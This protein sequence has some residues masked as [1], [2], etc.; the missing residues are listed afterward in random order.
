[1]QKN[2][3]F[4]ITLVLLLL[5]CNPSSPQKTQITYN[6][7]DAGLMGVVSP[8]E[9]EVANI[10]PWQPKILMRVAA[11]PVVDLRYGESGELRFP[12]PGRQKMS[13]C[14]GWAS[15]YSLKTYLEAVEHNWKLD[16][17]SRIFSPSFVYNQINGGKNRG[18]TIYNALLLFQRVGAA[19]LETMP[20]TLN[21]RKRPSRSA[22]REANNY[23]IK[24]F[25]RL[26]S[27]ADIRLALQ[28]GNP[29]LVHV[30]TDAT[31]NSGLYDVYTRAM[32]KKA[33]RVP[34]HIHGRHAM[35]IAGY[36][37]IGRTLLFINSWGKYWGTKGFARV[38]YDVI[39]RIRL[40]SAGT[41]FL[42]EAYIAIDA[43]SHKEKKKTIS[44]YGNVYYTGLAQ[45]EP[46]WSW[47]VY[48][49]AS[50]KTFNA[51]RSIRWKF[52]RELSPLSISKSSA[53]NFEVNGVGDRIG[54][55]KAIAYIKFKDGTSSKK[56]YL[57]DFHKTNRRALQLVQTDRYYGRVQKRPYWNWSL[58]IKGTLNDLHDIKKVTY[59]LHPTFPKPN[60]VVTRSAENGFQFSSRGWGTFPVKAT[61]LFQDGTSK[62]LATSLKFRSKV[63]DRLILTNK[64]IEAF[65]DTNGRLIYNWT[66]YLKGPEKILSSIKQVRYYLHRTFRKNKIDVYQQKYGFPLSRSGWGT[67]EIK[68]KVFFRNGRTKVLKHTLKF[69]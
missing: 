19:T 12:N 35:V 25:K 40:D 55:Y 44:L 32:R 37:D 15:A 6:Q 53:N 41:Y 63:E 30:I 8:E 23:K 39:D 64:A 11:A 54:Q 42:Q 31:F 22:Y 18:A 65:Q 43:H 27:L 9:Q 60:R 3:L 7:G 48:L 33:K 58:R 67:F 69:R 2:T 45:Q 46:T 68:A 4:L 61:V 24:D 62:R 13:D 56:T 26:R 50:E 20:Y 52:S 14:V 49:E 10:K 29:V 1:M 28:M 57:L 66:A 51:I 16:R 59:Y 34:G 47:R 36:N 5:T 17:P 21:Y 38:S